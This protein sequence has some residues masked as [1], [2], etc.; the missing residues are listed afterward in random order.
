M[1]YETVKNGQRASLIWLDEPSHCE[2]AGVVSV[3]S[4]LK[5]IGSARVFTGKE[6]ACLN[7]S[8]PTLASKDN[9]I[10]DS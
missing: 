6:S 9:N 8:T 3:A 10:W 5:T 1:V 4:S 7:Q 2:C